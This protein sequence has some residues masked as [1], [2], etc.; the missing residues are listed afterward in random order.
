MATVATDGKGNYVTLDSSGQWVPAAAPAPKGQGELGYAPTTPPEQPKSTDI[1]DTFASNAG[2]DTPDWMSSRSPAISR[3]AQAAVEGYKANT[4]DVTPGLIMSPI[5]YGL[6]QI[7]GVAGGLFRGGQQAVEEFTPSISLPSLP[8]GV[9]IPLGGGRSLSGQLT[10]GSLGREIAAM[11][12]AFPTGESGG[13]IGTARPEVLPPRPSPS[14][15][16]ANFVQ[17]YYGEHAPGTPVTVGDLTRAITRADEQPSGAA[18]AQNTLAPKPGPDQPAPTQG[19]A[20]PSQTGLTGAAPTQNTLAPKPGQDGSTAPPQPQPAPA[21][22][23]ATPASALGLTPAEEAAYQ[24]TA[25]GKKLL[26]AQQPGLQDRT[27]Y[28]PN[29]TPSS[30]DIEQTV[31][32]SRELKSL[33]Q[34][35]PDVSQAAR[36][37]ADDNNNARTAYFNK[38]AGS[39]VDVMNAKAAR[40]TQAQTDLKATWANKQ[41]ADASPV[42]DVANQILAGPDGKR[43][44]VV[45]AVKSVTDQ[46]RDSSGNLETDPELLYG[47]R[48]HIGDLLSKEGAQTDPL[49]Q[50]AKDNLIQLRDALDGVIEQAA[51]GFG[52]YLKNFATASKPID[53]MTALQEFAPRLYDAQ[54]RMQYSRVQSMMKQLV[55]ARNSPGVN[56]Y[57]SIPDDT[58]QS[59]WNL[60]DDLRRSAAAQD[61]AR[62]AGSDTA[63]NVWDAVRGVVSLKNAARALPAAGS[64]LGPL[65]V[66]GGQAAEAG[67]NRLLTNRALRQQTERGMEMLRPNTLLQP[68]PGTSPP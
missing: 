9:S 47:A 12:E 68:P 43:P 23:Q 32:T 24:A 22:A 59:L 63:Q 37:I 52:Q 62:T 29:V 64:F 6:A 11:P 46:L 5:N 34:T 35:A 49:A 56:P 31:N 53:A 15:P 28:V 66:I 42:L 14:I 10:P 61:L 58:M 55:D 30:A 41:D 38:Q 1:G 16:T 25:D 4:P 19:Q 51:P 2:T 60:R 57:K 65:G 44:A 20:P 45:N 27:A 67:I 54:N 39:P 50:R 36:E 21:G 33:G 26:E 7:P 40:D 18:P 17:E 48:K 3:V 13:T 8:P